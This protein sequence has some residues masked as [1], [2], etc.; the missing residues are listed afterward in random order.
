MKRIQRKRQREDD[1][2]KEN[3]TKSPVKRS[4]G[5]DVS[6]KTESSNLDSSNTIQADDEKIAKNDD[7]TV[8]DSDVKME[9][10]TE[11]EEDPEEDPE[12]Y[13]EMESGSPQHDSSNEKNDE[14]KTSTNVEPDIAVNDKGADE[15][16]KGEAKVKEV[17]DSKSDTKSKEEREDKVDKN[18]KETH[19]AK[20]AAVNKELL[21]V[22]SCAFYT[23][24]GCL[25]TY[26]NYAN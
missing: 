25:F 11:V 19:A 17:K 18:K 7:S 26:F 9:D 24:P 20:E 12:E 2:E 21:Q 13:E 15:T 16:S 6:V 5:D 22:F 3:A 10:G 8:K 1:H 14:Q 4:K 23:L